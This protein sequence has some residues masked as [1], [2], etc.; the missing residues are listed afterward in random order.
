MSSH[1]GTLVDEEKG[2]PDANDTVSTTRSESVEDLYIDPAAEKELV[3]KIDLTILPL[4]ILVYWVSYLDRANIANAKAAGMVASLGL[5]TYDFNTGACVYFVVY[6]FCEPF[7]GLAVKRWG[8]ILIPISVLGFAVITLATA[9]IKNSG[10][11][12][13]VRC[14]LGAVEAF[15]MP[16]LSYVLSRYYRRHE[17]TARFGIFMLVAIGCSQ[18]FGGLLSGALVDVGSIGNVKGWSLIF[19]V[20]GIITIGIAI[21]LIIFF[22]SDPTT[23]RM[24][25]PEQRKLALMRLQADAPPGEDTKEP[26]SWAGIKMSFLNLNMAAYCYMYI[27]NCMS[28]Q[29]LAIFTTSIL[30]VIYP[31][32]STKRIQYLSVGPQVVGAFIGILGCFAA[33]RLQRQGYIVLAGAG[34]CIFAYIILISTAQQAS[35]SY[36]SLRYF[37]LFIVTGGGYIYAPC[38]LG[39]A[40]SNASPDTTRSLTGAL[41]TGLGSIG[42]IASTWSYIATDAHTGFRVGNAL[43]I[44]MNVGT[45]LVCLGLMAYQKKE[46][47]LREGG[48]RDYRLMKPHP[49]KLGRHHPAY[50]YKI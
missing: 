14:L 8:F 5:G 44:G 30:Q 48:G 49:E 29:G 9:W 25:T 20:E 40:M 39:W 46:N 41:V 24:F 17:L 6:I 43:N 16:G 32:A 21:F 33:S 42:S 1:S 19:L 45:V 15:S 10:Q 11:F 47:R 37:A 4:A 13:A 26:I 7:A 34:L 18:G 36:A 38:V 2:V 27:A 22:P 12:Y 50:R 28:S 23:T 3:W 31:D 35:S